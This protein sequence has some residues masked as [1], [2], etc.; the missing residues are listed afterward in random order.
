MST[1]E[2]KGIGTFVGT[3]ALPAMIFTAL[4]TLNL[5]SVNWNFL[6]S[7]LITKTVVFLAV[8]FVSLLVNHGNNMGKAGLYSIFVTQSND[9]ALGYP[10]VKALYGQSHPEYPSYLYLISPISL[11]I[12]N[13]IG[14]VLMEVD[15]VRSDNQEIK[16]E[17]GDKLSINSSS[18][19]SSETCSVG[20][21]N[22]STNRQRIIETVLEIERE[23]D[24]L[25]TKDN[26]GIHGCTNSAKITHVVQ[27]KSLQDFRYNF[28]VKTRFSNRSKTVCRIV[29]GIFSNPII[30]LTFAGVIFGQFVFR[31]HVPPVIN[32]FL[33]TLKSA[34]SATALFSLGLGMV[35]RME[36][37]K[38]GS[39]L[40]GPVL[41]IAT[42]IILMPL[43][44]REITNFL[45]AGENE[46]ES[47]Q[48]ADFAFL[49][50][51]FP[52]A[53]TVYVIATR[54]GVASSII[55]STMVACTF[56]S[57]PIMFISGNKYS[58]YDI[59]F[60]FI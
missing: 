45:D 19:D 10:I 31:G 57:A 43:M 28:S 20:G 1:A 6:L 4:C 16:S 25:Y 51:T 40:L 29:F 5:S 33:H 42:K 48:L 35:G 55:A 12:L 3:F 41:L 24:D 23:I 54:Y 27:D 11:A 44:A 34:Y 46:E 49:Y 17:G 53:P 38:S 8:L 15:K 47:N 39:K 9:F 32:N 18:T 58:Q 22:L 59:I 60:L 14:C 2:A 30:I 21:T 26:K 56:L 13:P 37:F 7:I 50:G 52:T 36:A